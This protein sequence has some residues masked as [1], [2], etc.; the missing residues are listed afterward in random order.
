MPS[1]D[2]NAPFLTPSPTAAD[3][4]S[5]AAAPS[6]GAHRPSALSKASGATTGTMAHAAD[7][8]FEGAPSAPVSE[9]WQ[10][11]FDILDAMKKTKSGKWTPN[12]HSQPNTNTRIIGLIDSQLTELEKLKEK[13]DTALK[14]FITELMNED[15]INA[16]ASCCSRSPEYKELK[17]LQA[18]IDRGQLFK[19]GAT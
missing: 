10:K 8:S 12:M 4:T 3:R 9:N 17:N 7:L 19:M 2:L 14:T 1:N 11:C 18:N 6:L 16:S 15:F 13:D 5:G